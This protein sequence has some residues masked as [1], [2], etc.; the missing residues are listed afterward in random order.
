MDKNSE[1]IFML[2]SSISD[3]AV[4]K[5]YTPSEWH[6]LASKAE[7]A[8]LQP[9]DL[10]NMSDNELKDLDMS[11][12]DINRFH[13]LINDGQKLVFK[14]EK[15]ESMGVSIITAADKMYPKMLKTKLKNGCPPLFYCMG[16]PKLTECNCIGFVGSRQAT[17]SDRIFTEKIVSKINSLGYS[18]VSGGARGIDDIAANM[19]VANGKKA[20]IYL[21]DSMIKKFRSKQI[22]SAVCDGQMLLLSSVSPYA[23]FTSASAMIRNRYIYAHSMGTVVVHS[24]YKKGGTW[25]GAFDCIKHKISPVFCANNMQYKGNAELIKLGAFPID[26]NWNGDLTFQEDTIQLSLS[27]L[28][29][30]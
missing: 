23:E 6:K 26:E 12:D 5:P 9:Y 19:S 25:N 24:D 18:V 27:D 14:A 30:Y 15:Y 13:K 16:D 17:S 20:V 2:C 4:N 11:T 7:K 3:N 1:V 10:L 29:E 8:N 28:Y 22:M 21:A